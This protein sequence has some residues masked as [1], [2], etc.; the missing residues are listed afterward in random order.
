VQEVG[1]SGEAD[2]THVALLVDFDN[3]FPGDVPDEPGMAHAINRMLEWALEAEPLADRVDIRLYG[4][5]QQDGVFTRRASELLA[6][7]GTAV[8][9]LRHPTRDGLLRGSVAL[10]TRLHAVPRLEWAHTVRERRG[11]PRVQLESTPYPAGCAEVTPECPLHAIRK[12]SRRGSRECRVEACRVTNHG[13]FRVLE[14][15][16]VD[17]MLACDAVAFAAENSY[18]VVLSSDLDVLPGVAMAAASRR[19]RMWLVRITD[20]AAALYEE[21]LSALG[22]VVGEWAA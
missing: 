21:E 2:D 18:V 20:D 8:F 17:V 15:K 12:L 19:G 6:V 9:P 22:V 11:L 5:W 10:V 14:Q 1:S 7:V 13:A 3:F 4:G 16:M